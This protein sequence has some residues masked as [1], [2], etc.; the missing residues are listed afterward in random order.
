MPEQI[1]P[2]D[3][4]VKVAFAVL[5]DTHSDGTAVAV[6]A[7]M[8]AAGE[9]QGVVHLGDTEDP[10][11]PDSIEKHVR[12]LAV[13]GNRDIRNAFLPDRTVFE[14]G[15]MRFAGV[16]GH[17]QQVKS[18]LRALPALADACAA[19]VVLFGHTHRFSVERRRTPSGRS[20][21]LLNPGAGFGFGRLPGAGFL[22]LT[23]QA[24]ELRIRRILAAGEFPVDLD[25]TDPP[26]SP[27]MG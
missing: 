3:P 11:W 21:T 8:A 25:P 23:V 22:I 10:R 16:H 18:G 24:G 27:S 1:G 13:A 2:I 12:V 20:V 9:I 17:I 19:D 14:A 26:G 6:I 15:G 4:S 5:S 7:E